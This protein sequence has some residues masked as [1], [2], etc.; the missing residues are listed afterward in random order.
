MRKIKVDQIKEHVDAVL[1][2]S[3]TVHPDGIEQTL[4]GMGL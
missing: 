1:N 2:S 3:A 4:Q